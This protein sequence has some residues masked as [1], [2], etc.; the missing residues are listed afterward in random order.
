MSAL[1]RN[2]QV[3]APT[4][5]KVL[6]P[7]I[8]WRGIARGALVTSMWTG[9]VYGHRALTEVPVVTREHLPQLEKIQKVLPARRDEA[10]FR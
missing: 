10:D 3:L 1:E 8:D 9:F 2:P 7:S 4:P 6:G 5:H